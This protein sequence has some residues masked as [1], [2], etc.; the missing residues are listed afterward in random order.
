MFIDW[1][2]VTAILRPREQADFATLQTMCERGGELLIPTSDFKE[3]F[4]FEP[5][6][7][8]SIVFVFVLVLEEES[9]VL[10]FPEEPEVR[11]FSLSVG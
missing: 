2:H 1:A 7:D 6:P 10:S 8:L 9:S 5:C 4:V 3:F 11:V